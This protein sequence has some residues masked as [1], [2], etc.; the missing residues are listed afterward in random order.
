MTT[1]LHFKFTLIH[2]ILQVNWHN[3]NESCAHLCSDNRNFQFLHIGFLSNIL[4]AF[5]RGCMNMKKL[6][7]KSSA[8]TIDFWKPYLKHFLKLYISFVSKNPGCS[9]W[10]MIIFK[11]NHHYPEES[12]I[13][14]P[15]Y[16]SKPNFAIADFN[17]HLVGMC[18]CSTCTSQYPLEAQLRL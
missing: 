11:N 12:S 17:D 8:D 6:S 9:S 3:S 14:P 4:N 15:N 1:C 5:H 10:A 18:C 7:I 13:F 16:E 2:L